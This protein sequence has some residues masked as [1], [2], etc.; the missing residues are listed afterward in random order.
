LKRWLIL[1]YR[2][3]SLQEAF[4]KRMITMLGV[5]LICCSFTYG[6]EERYSV[7][8]EDT[9]YGIDLH[10]ISEERSSMC[11]L[12]LAGVEMRAPT[13]GNSGALSI[14]VIT[15]PKGFVAQ[16]PSSSIAA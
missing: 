6:A 5:F 15:D 8:I 3:N 1:T 9:S 16:F 7:R 13:E 12:I 10:V 11:P 14:H 4:M 2:F